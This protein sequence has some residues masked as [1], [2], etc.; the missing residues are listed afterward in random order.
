MDRDVL[1]EIYRGWRAIADGYAE[2]RVLIGELWLPDGAVD[3]L[4]PHRRTAHTAF[5]FDY[6]S[7][8]WEPSRMRECIDAS[9]AVH[10]P[11]MRR[12]RG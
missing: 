2:P 12:P 7:C 9:L 6:L 1:H 11:S 4:P 8:A 10:A 5:N 3:P